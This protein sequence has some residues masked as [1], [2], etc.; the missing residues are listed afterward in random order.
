VPRPRFHKL[1]AEKRDAILDAAGQE[2]AAHGF[3]Q[4]SLNTILGAAGVSKGAFYYYFD[5]KA[6]LFA[7]VLEQL[8]QVYG[9]GDALEI[10]AVT[11]ETFWPRLRDLNRS[12]FADTQDKPWLLAIGKAFYDLPPAVRAQGRIGEVVHRLE[13]FVLSLVRRG[14]AVGALRTDLPAPLI[15][16]IFTALDQAFAEWMPHGL[17]G[18]SAA[19]LEDFEGAAFDLLRRVAAPA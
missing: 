1:P 19:E 7:T 15:V 14:Q 11:R 3:E 13:D 18:L 9:W 16:R 17:A 10:E 5:D 6:D 8:E 2:F 4:A 12:A